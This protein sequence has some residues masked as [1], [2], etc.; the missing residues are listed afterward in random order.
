MNTF[1]LSIAGIFI[2]ILTALFAI[3]YFV[4]WNSYRSVFEA[5]ASR[6]VGREVRVGG[7]VNLR[8]LPV[9]YMSFENVRVA[10]VTGR[11]DRPFLKLDAYTVWLSIPP[12]LQ[13]K[14]EAREMDLKHPRLR[15]AIDEAGRGNW[16]GLGSSEVRLP[17]MPQDVA[18]KSVRIRDG[19]LQFVSP[20]GQA[21]I[22]AHEIG[23]EFQAQ[24][25]RGPYRFHGSFAEGD[26]RR[27]LRFS[28]GRLDPARGLTFKATMQA[29]D[30]QPLYVLEG[31]LAHDGERLRLE[32]GLTGRMAFA[33][34]AGHAK[35]GD[36]PE[37]EILELKATVQAD[38]TRLRIASLALTF[39]SGGH[40]Q[41]I[42]GEAGARW[43]QELEANA[44]LKA[45]WLDLDN[46]S[47]AGKKPTPQAVAE[48]AARIVQNVMPRKVRARVSLDVEQANIGGALVN[49]VAVR[50]RR[51]GDGVRIE[52]FRARL[53]GASQIALA[54]D[55]FDRPSGKV[56]FKGRFNLHG[57]NLG[58][59]V[60]WA[61]QGDAL[62]QGDVEKFFTLRSNVVF[63]EDLM[64]IADAT[65]ELGGAAFRVSIRQTGGAQKVLRVNFDSDRLD[66][67][68]I[69]DPKFTVTDLYRLVR[70][71]SGDKAAGSPF[72]RFLEEK[73]RL[74]IKARIGS[75]LLG[76]RM[77]RDFAT[78]AQ[79]D[80][81]T[82][83][84]RALRVS[85]DDGLRLD[86]DGGVGT[87]SGDPK[88]EI[89][90]LVET[91]RLTAAQ[92]FL[93]FLGLEKDWVGREYLARAVAP[94]RIAGVLAF[95]RRGAKTVD[96]TADGLVGAS[97][98]MVQARS[99]GELRTLRDNLVDV[100]ATVESDDARRL[101][102]MLFPRFS[103]GVPVPDETI[104]AGDAGI[105]QESRTNTG[106]GAGGRLSVRIGGVAKKGLRTVVALE[107]RA[108]NAEFN[109]K[110]RFDQDGGRA[111]TGE[112]S[113][114]ADRA[115][116]ALALV[117]LAGGYARS[118]SPLSIG[119]NLA[120]D[121]PTLRLT[122]LRLQA[123]GSALVGRA[124]LKI[125][126]PAL[127]VSL[128]ASLDKASVGQIMALAFNDPAARP[129]AGDAGETRA[130][131]PTA[132]A[133]TYGVAS[134]GQWLSD[135]PFNLRLLDDI[136]GRTTLRVK[137]LAL[138]T[139]L[140]MTD[141]AM[142]LG[143]NGDEI[144]LERFDG[145]ALGGKVKARGVLRRRK[146]GV[147]L[148]LATDWRGADLARIGASRPDGRVRA[149]GKSN[150][151]FNVAGNG[152]SP[153]GLAAVLAGSGT[154]ELTG[155]RING[156]SPR[157]VDDTADVIVN[158]GE[159]VKFNS[160]ELVTLITR[161]L[162]DGRLDLGGLTVPFKVR[163]GALR[164]GP[165][166]IKGGNA[167]FKVTTFID[168]TQ[169]Q[170]D[171]EW[172]LAPRARG[173]KSLPPVTV[174]YKGSVAALGDLEPQVEAGALERELT[175]RKMEADVARLE[176]LRQIE[177]QRQEEQDRLERERLLQA[178]KQRALDQTGEGPGGQGQP[179][180]GTAGTNL[181]NSAGVVPP[182][183]EV[184][185]RNPNPNP[186]QAG[187]AGE[188]GGTT[189]PL[190]TRGIR[191]KPVLDV[192]VLRVEI[193]AANRRRRQK[194]REDD[195]RSVLVPQSADATGQP[196]PPQLQPRRRKR[197][198]R[199]VVPAKPKSPKQVVKRR[200][201]FPSLER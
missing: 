42:T 48:T 88:G 75:L 91:S 32:G 11:F 6:L 199:N 54:G 24:T 198:R 13:G 149:R 165:V 151:R 90:Y 33:N 194:N 1:L 189:V 57:S 51:D 172:V 166:A 28:T 196:N 115:P 118:R 192:R 7:N 98:A 18:L 155:G 59:F 174:V 119:A 193:E 195:W 4:D 158:L 128:D 23:G 100:A 89:R 178:E 122:D 30:A 82:L 123:E 108:L 22:D 36:T 76:G 139:G 74:Q 109:G 40:P 137:R 97:R 170:I 25:L 31:Q 61:M 9:P 5:Q 142:S 53:P 132:P 181:Q 99:D 19:V 150:L 164:T 44:N 92:S 144:R 94:L 60:A 169:F 2:A 56:G 58:R 39:E 20:V 12:L 117:G 186:N 95:G 64:A 78:D 8:L 133:G 85:S 106:I 179:T 52:R 69:F 183:P 84:V 34:L 171:S 187:P 146:A 79:L 80:H 3:P 160:D 14:L 177:K 16:E 114:E 135:K 10:N 107:S 201:I 134:A 83:A 67:S 62:E 50:V 96:L 38:T 46:F 110:V 47:T 37:N 124:S 200:P 71:V 120:I 112:V 93:D 173:P 116:D 147:R 197:R 190:P 63:D 45:R 35:A 121:G 153:R 104:V 87:L 141:A 168:L 15:L 66:L 167:G 73:G 65:G 138:A 162:A 70:P 81:D 152:L 105:P 101:F 72:A 159:D 77:F 103:P 157:A 185:A 148:E 136:T 154:L 41:L 140:V 175:V 68:N 27:E 126:E 55:L 184:N 176:K 26:V 145:R 191:P 125:A 49:Q 129:L 163:D 102:A 17:F 182:Q 180:E 188:A 43:G 127:V 130:D 111:I 86:A 21:L 161:K 29:P 156:L 113:L 143:L 131:A